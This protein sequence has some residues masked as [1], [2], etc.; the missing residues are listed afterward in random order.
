LDSLDKAEAVVTLKNDYFSASMYAMNELSGVK[1][2]NYLASLILHNF[3]KIS[4]EDFKLIEETENSLTF[5]AKADLSHF[6][7]SSFSKKYIP[8]TPFVYLNGDILERE[9]DSLAIFLNERIQTKLSLEIA[10]K[11]FKLQSDSLI[12]GDPD[13]KLYFSTY[14]TNKSD[15]IINISYQLR[16]LEK[17]ITPNRKSAFF[18]FYEQYSASKTEMYILK[19][20]E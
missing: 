14:S 7:I 17:K 4:L 19:E 18:R 8:K 11:N 15:S 10:S 5:A 3:Y 13:S 1:L 6:L 2:E 9:K 20:E 16:Q 12:L